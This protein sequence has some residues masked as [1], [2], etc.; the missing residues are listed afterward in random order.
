MEILVGIGIIVFCVWLFRS[1]KRTY[2][3]EKVTTVLESMEDSIVKLF[4]ELAPTS[5]RS[6]TDGEILAVSRQ[7]MRAFQQFAVL[8]GETIP[9]AYLLNIAF[10]FVVLYETSGREFYESHLK[11]ELDRYL[12]LGLREHYKKD[13]LQP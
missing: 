8:R 1:T 10:F 12:A 11:Y 3:E 7:T 6:L 5:L 2:R 4:R 9:G 13:M